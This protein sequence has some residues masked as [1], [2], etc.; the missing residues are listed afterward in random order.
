MQ[1]VAN[2][3]GFSAYWC[4]CARRRCGLDNCDGVGAVG[5]KR[6]C[7]VCLGVD[8][9]RFVLVAKLALLCLRPWRAL[10]GSCWL[11]TCVCRMVFVCLIRISEFGIKP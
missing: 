4:L 3:G 6:D 8:L 1:T 9:E 11:I 7:D 5:F 2:A 10:E